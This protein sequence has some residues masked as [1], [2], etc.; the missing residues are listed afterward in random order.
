M[1]RVKRRKP[2]GGKTHSSVPPD[3]SLASKIRICAIIVSVLWLAYLG[4][5]TPSSEVGVSPDGAATSRSSA[6]GWESKG[7]TVVSHKTPLAYGTKSGGAQTAQLVKDA[8]TLGFRHIVTGSHHGAHNETGVGHGWKDSGV[9]RQDLFL[10][11]CFVPWNA[12]EFVTQPGDP[13]QAPATIQEQV[14]NSIRI[15]LS[16]LQTDYIDAVIFHNF[17]AK[18]YPFDEM[19]QAWGVLESYVDKGVIRHL[20][21]TSVHDE[22]HW[23]RLF[24]VSRIHPT[25]LQNRFHGNRGYDVERQKLFRSTLGLQLQRFWLLNGSSGQGRNN[26]DMAERKGMTPQQLLLAFV[27]SL[28]S[29]TCLVGTHNL[30]HMKD[31]L[32]VAKCYRYVFDGE[33][34]RQEYAQKLGYRPKSWENYDPIVKQEQDYATCKAKLVTQ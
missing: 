24:N 14:H 22:A 10:Q 4:S 17:R 27:M 18:L 20:G 12:K 6:P 9:Q 8:I 13:E 28:G 23:Q 26:K 7:G 15:S 34:E 31:D 29:N 11:T 1:V 21:M 19:I 33:E 16:N 3:S 32:E 30:Q 5:L 25:I 2:K